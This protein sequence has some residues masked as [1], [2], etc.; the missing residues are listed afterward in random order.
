VA[1]PTFELI[2][3]TTLPSASSSITFS[4]I[5][6]DWRD[7]HLVFKLR[8]SATRNAFLTFNG[9][10]TGTNYNT[11]RIL[12]T[13]SSTSSSVYFEQAKIYTAYSITYLDNPGIFTATI[14]DYAQTNKD[15]ICFIEQGL[16]YGTGANDGYMIRATGMWESTSAITSLTLTEGGGN[17]YPIGTTAELY[18]I[19]G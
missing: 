9:E 8:D 15:K 13:G 5:A 19:A 2:D 1:T 11:T 3:S 18:G 10:T 4:G 16:S 6:S 14:F 12:S 17:N 7:L